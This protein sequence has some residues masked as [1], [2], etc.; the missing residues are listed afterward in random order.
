MP[1]LTPEQQLAE[2][3][4]AISAL[5]AGAEEVQLDGQRVRLPSLQALTERETVLLRRVDRAARGRAVSVSI[6]AGR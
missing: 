3:Q 5:L 6:G 2:V 4:A 1:I